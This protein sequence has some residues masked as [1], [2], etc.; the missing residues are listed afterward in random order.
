MVCQKVVKGRVSAQCTDIAQATIQ[1]PPEIPCSTAIGYAV[2]NFYTL[3]VTSELQKRWGSPREGPR[4]RQH[5]Y[6]R[7]LRPVFEANQNSSVLPP[8]ES[9]TVAPR[10]AFTEPSIA[11][12]RINPLI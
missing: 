9:P 10:I 8:D 11:G 12:F 7:A 4:V 5:I 3:E 6:I 2:A 1:I